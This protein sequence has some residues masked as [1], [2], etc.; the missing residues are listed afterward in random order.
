MSLSCKPERVPNPIFKSILDFMRE[1]ASA[2]VGA[3]S[4]REK[5]VRYLFR[6]A[7]KQNKGDL[8]GAITDFTKVIELKPDDAAACFNRATAKQAKGDLDGAIVDRTKAIQLKA[9]SFR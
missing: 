8:D 5:W 2:A 3:T 4:G 9:G 1:S 6:G 7:E